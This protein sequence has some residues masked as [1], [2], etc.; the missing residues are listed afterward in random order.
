VWEG[1]VRLPRPWNLWGVRGI[2]Y[3]F[4]A[5]GREIVQFANISNESCSLPQLDDYSRIALCSSFSRF[6]ELYVVRATSQLSLTLRRHPQV[7]L[8]DNSSLC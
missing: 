1:G 3:L 5:V 6:P 4:M 8:S 2:S 7:S